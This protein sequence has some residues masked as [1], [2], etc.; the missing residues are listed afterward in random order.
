MCSGGIDTIQSELCKKDLG[1]FYAIL[2][3]VLTSKDVVLTW[4][5]IL[6]KTIVSEEAVVRKAGG[7]FK[8]NPLFPSTVAKI[9][10]VST[11]FSSAPLTVNEVANLTTAEL[12]SRRR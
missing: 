1:K 6:A 4:L 7:K 2:W 3:V 8:M 11:S 5:D 12:A 10:A 9:K